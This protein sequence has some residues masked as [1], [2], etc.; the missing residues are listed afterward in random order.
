M[1]DIV[2]EGAFTNWKFTDS[3]GERFSRNELKLMNEIYLNTPSR[4]PYHLAQELPHK[5]TLLVHAKYDAVVPAENG[6]LLWERAG[7]PERWVFASGHL[8]L[9]MTF[10][11]HTHDIVQWLNSAIN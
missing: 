10:D 7:Y 1:F 8:G 11:W 6:D 5:K 2:Q 9:F 4:D 3:D